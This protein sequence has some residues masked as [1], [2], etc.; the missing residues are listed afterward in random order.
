M[1]N[2]VLYV[3]GCSFA[4]GMGIGRTIEDNVEG[5]FST[6]LGKF[7]QHDVM[8]VAV[9]GSCNQRIARRTCLD[10]IKHRPDIAIVI[11]S[12]PARFEFVQDDYRRYVNN[13]DCEQVRPLS[14]Y[15]YPR[16]RRQ[17]F[18]DYYTH[19]SSNHRDIFF[20]LQN[21]LSVKMTADHL[22]VPCIQI[23]F[24]G[25]F[26]R[27]LR[28]V[29]NSKNPDYMDSLNDYIDVL[30]QDPLIFGILEDISFDSISGC[31][32]DE[33]MLSSI[34]QQEGH[35]NGEAH[36][37]MSEWLHVLLLDHGLV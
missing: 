25:S 32:V 36:N 24:K 3:N 5:R 15:S 26:N 19:I 20:T 4:Y 17:A 35:P 6:S 7:I 28:K 16:S 21:M 13:E 18:L 37:I 10:L 12:D 34:R 8:N 9:P 1:K 33:S 11:W 14:V 22:G 29:M 30:S 31:D 27:E 2:K 23:P